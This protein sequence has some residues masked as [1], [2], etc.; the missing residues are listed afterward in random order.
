MYHNI[1]KATHFKPI[2]DIILNDKK[3]KP[4]SLRLG[5]RLRIP[6]LATSIQYSTVKP[7]QNTKNK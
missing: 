3:L 6:S 1:I 5:I 2:V 7:S 4:F